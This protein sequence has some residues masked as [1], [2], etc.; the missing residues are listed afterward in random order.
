MCPNNSH[1]QF[2][3]H[4]DT[5]RH[6]GYVYE[7]G[8]RIHNHPEPPPAMRMAEIV[9]LAAG[10]ATVSSVFPRFFR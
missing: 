4:G 5:C 1:K 9:V 8:E 6:C 10:V 3:D 2:A 7:H